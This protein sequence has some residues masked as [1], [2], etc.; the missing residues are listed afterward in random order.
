MLYLMANLAS[1]IASV[2]F[3]IGLYQLFQLIITLLFSK[4]FKIK[5]YFF[6]S[7]NLIIMTKSG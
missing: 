5:S 4:Y 2:K 3:D 6:K 1:C 7:Q